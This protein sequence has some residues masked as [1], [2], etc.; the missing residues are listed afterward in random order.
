[1]KTLINNI[2][3]YNG[4]NEPAQK[5]NVLIDEGRIA[6]ISNSPISDPAELIIEGDGKWLT[7]GFVDTHTHYDAEILLSPG[8]K[9]SVR[10][11]VTTAVI[12]SCSISMVYDHQMG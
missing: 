12:G 2:T 11:G 7:P 9:E 10:H 5:T 6:K 3:L 8:L 4:K 1:M